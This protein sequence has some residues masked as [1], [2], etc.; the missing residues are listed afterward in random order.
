MD[1]SG[2]CE[3][4][5]T[6]D[7]GLDIGRC[8]HHQVGELVDHA[9]DVRQFFLGN[10]ERII[11]ARHFHVAHGGT[12]FWCHFGIHGFSLGLL[13][14]ILKQLRV[15]ASDIAHVGLGKN[16]VAMLHL[17]NQPFQRTRHFLGLSHHWNQHMR[18]RI[19]HLH[20][21]HFGVDHDEA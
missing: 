18:Q 14:L 16:L 13:F 21:H 7:T 1:T 17:S 12:L 19:I 20:L 3:L 2:T 5:D 10:F 4:R 6:R 11:I 15:K 8:D 9:D